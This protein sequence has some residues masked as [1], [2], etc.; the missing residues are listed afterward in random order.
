MILLIW[1]VLL[2]GCSFNAGKFSGPSP[3]N[4]AGDREESSVRLDP[5]WS[6]EESMRAMVLSDLHFTQNA[7]ADLTLVPGIALSEEI[8]DV[9]IAELIDRHPDVLIMTG[10]NTD[11]GRDTDV[12][13]LVQKLQRVREEEISIILTT[14]NH[15]FNHM[16]PEEFEEAW[17]G[18]LD[19][20]DRDPDSL[21]YTAIVK[22]VVFLAMDDNSLYNGVHGEFS[23]A[24][25]RW[26][27][28]MLMKYSGKQI[29]FLSHHNVLYEY[30][31]EN[32]VSNL[33]RNPEL[34][35]LLTEGGVRLVFTGHMHS[36][37]ITKRKEL[38]EILSGMPF[39]GEHLIGNLAVG[40]DK[41]LYYAEP[42]DFEKYDSS[43][44]E[45]LDRLDRASAEHTR[46]MFSAVLEQKGLR[47]A[48]K[49]GVQG[50]LN[51]NFPNQ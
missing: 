24:T 16:T 1:P 12:H 47:G 18:L 8:T 29:I 11:S 5:V 4:S 45:E 34:P 17:F 33:I 43:V 32:S 3:Q 27:G 37:Y 22:D 49:S 50:L 7:D 19:P 36:Q 30:G 13:G 31:K 9:I 48:G 46:Q 14:G 26:I 21:S 40:T 23:A 41:M 10:D 25:M 35:E 2:A 39:S 38:W 51:Y 42:I 6:D 15:D 44:A 20:V 28:E